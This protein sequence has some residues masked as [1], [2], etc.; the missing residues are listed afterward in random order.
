MRLR[1]VVTIKR[2]EDFLFA[3]HNGCFIGSFG[4]F[5]QVVQECSEPLGCDVIRVGFTV[6]K[7]VGKAVVRNKVK[8][9]FRVLAENIIAK[10]ARRGYCYILIASKDTPKI[11]FKDMLSRLVQYLNTSHL[12][13]KTL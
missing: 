5:L 9:R 8:R 12:Y 7:K 6:S 3:K 13:S 10:H 4:L 11:K 1:G 2:R